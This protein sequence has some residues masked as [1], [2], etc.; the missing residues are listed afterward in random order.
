MG[1]QKV[2]FLENINEILSV[3]HKNGIKV[4]PVV[5]DK[6]SFFIEVDYSGRKKRGSTTYNWK[7]Q[8]K[9]MQNKI[10]ELYEELAKKIQSRK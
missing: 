6:N 8:Q 5:C 2:S 3:C 9:E 1:K 4:Y 7:T 10:I